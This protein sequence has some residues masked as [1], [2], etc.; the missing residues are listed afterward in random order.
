V[1]RAVEARTAELA[2]AEYRVRDVLVSVQGE[3]G[4]TYMELR[5]AQL[6]L[7]VAERNAANQASTFDL[8]KILLAGGRGTELDTAR[9]EAQLTTTRATIPPLRAIVQQSR[10]R[11]AV[12]TGV[13]PEAL[14]DE[15]A[16]RA[17][18]PRLPPLAAV[19]TPGDLVRRRPD[20]SAAESDLIAASARK[21]VQVADLFPRVTFVGSVALEAQSVAKLGAGGADTFSFGPRVFWAAFDLGRVRARIQAADAALQAALARY[22]R[23]V[24]LALE[25]TE[26]ALVTYAREQE[27]RDVLRVAAAASELATVRARERYQYGVANFLEV[28]DTERRLLEVQVDLANSETTTA[29]ALVAVYKALGGGWIV[30]PTTAG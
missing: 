13:P 2:A 14:V 21:G 16:A 19:G 29:R 25:E 27:R 5:G 30:P 11:L 12:L 8:T 20:V 15:L 18:L 23:T 22:E 1:R 10:H 4:Q 17:P 3:V 24:L 7:D 6:R 28:L 9:A 26:N